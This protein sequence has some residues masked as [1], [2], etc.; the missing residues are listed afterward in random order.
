M[1]IF[2]EKNKMDYES[3]IKSQ[4]S[5]E[6]KYII[7][8]SNTRFLIYILKSIKNIHNFEWMRFIESAKIDFEIK[9]TKYYRDYPNEFDE[10]LLYGKVEKWEILNEN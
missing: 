3:N 5:S 10:F 1:S 9:Y 2:P 7:D 6:L 8:N 4:V